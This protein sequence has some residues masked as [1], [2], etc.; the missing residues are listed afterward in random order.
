MVDAPSFTEF[1]RGPDEQAVL[2]LLTHLVGEGPAYFFRD[3]CRLLK[4]EPGLRS[5][6]HLLSHLCREVDSAIEQFLVDPKAV[7]QGRLL[8]SY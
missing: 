7:A 3:A 8:K 2:D 6:A 4:Q 5:A 1:A